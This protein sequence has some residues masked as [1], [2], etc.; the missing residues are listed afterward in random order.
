V[1][2]PHLSAM[3]SLARI[4]KE[5]SHCSSFQTFPTT[6]T[7]AHGPGVSNHGLGLVA[8]ELDYPPP[9]Y[10]LVASD[11]S[12]RSSSF[13]PGV[14]YFPTY[15]ASRLSASN[16]SCSSQRRRIR[17]QSIELWVTIV[18]VSPESPEKERVLALTG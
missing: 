11:R 3:F 13:F 8:Q 12:S 10:L 15:W 18:K 9:R 6:I 7:Q 5:Y 1:E 2:F 16:L 14:F 4:Y 17:L